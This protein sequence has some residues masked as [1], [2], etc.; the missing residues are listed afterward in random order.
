MDSRTGNRSGWMD[1][2]YDGNGSVNFD[3]YSLMD[4]AFNTQAGVL[5]RWHAVCEQ[6]SIHAAWSLIRT[7]E[8]EKTS[9]V[10]IG[11]RLLFLV[12]RYEEKSSPHPSNHA[13]KL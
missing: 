12:A 7:L 6:L 11:G 4:Q 3:D 5:L 9:G 8:A 10:P 2:D 1:G 13:S